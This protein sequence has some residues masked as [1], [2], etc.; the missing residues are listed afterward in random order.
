MRSHSQSKGSGQRHPSHIRAIAGRPGP[1]H[2]HSGQKSLRSQI[3]NFSAGIRA[4]A[5]LL[6]L[7]LIA[8]T[9]ASGLIGLTP[10]G[11]AQAAPGTP[12]T[13]GAPSLIYQEDFQNAPLTGATNIAAYTS[14][15]GATY[16][17]DSVYQ[18]ASRCNG[19]IFGHQATDAA[20]GAAQF[21]AASWWPTAR[22]VPAAIG[23]HAGMADPNTNL[24]VAEQTAGGFND[25]TGVMME[26][27]GINVGGTGRFVTF[28]LDVGNLCNIG[29]QALDR[30]Y[31]ING[32]TPI[33]LNATDYNIC[34]DPNRQTYTVDG[35]V[36]SV[37]TF[38]GNQA[39]LVTNPTVGFRV[40]N[41]QPNGS[42]NDQAFDNFK[43][44]DVT[45]QLDKS[46]S[47]ASVPVGSTSTLTLTVTNTSELGAKNGWSFTDALPT[48]LTV[49][50]PATT[51]C[52][53][54][55]VTAAAGGT[56]VG[57]TGNLSTGL[58]SCTVTVNV[59]SKAA[60]SFTNGPSNVTGTGINPPGTSTVNFVEQPWACDA[61]GYLFQSP[62]GLAD[63]HL[64]QKVD[65]VSGAFS[66]AFTM[67]EA[68]N[69]VGYNVLDNYFYG[70]ASGNGAL[71]RI[72]AN[73]SVAD[74]GVPAG[75][76]GG[77]FVIGDIDNAGRYWVTNGTAYYAIDLVPGSPTF[78]TVLSSGTLPGTNM[79]FD[80][81]FTN[82][83]FYSVGVNGANNVLVSFDPVTGT[84]TV[85]PVLTS[86]AG[87]PVTGLVVG[88]VY[89]DATGYLYASD[90]TTGNISRIDVNTAQMV[91]LSAGPASGGNDGARCASAP[92]PTLTVTK[93]VS[94]R[95][96]PAD[97][98]TVG[99]QA[100]A[101]A[102]LTSA[103]TTGTATTVSTLNQPVS[104]GST[105]TITDAMAAGS[106][107]GINAYNASVACT[108]TATGAT[109]PTAGSGPWTFTVPSAAA[110]TCNVT[111]A[112]VKVSVGLVK[113]ADQAA[114]NS[115]QL[116]QVITYSFEF[117]NTGDVPLT[118]IRINETGFTGTGTAPV[119][120]CPTG[121]V[122]PAAAVTCT[123]TYTVTQADVDAGSISNTATGTGTPPPGITTPPVSPP[124][125]VIVPAPPAPALTV[126]KS[127]SPETITAAG[128]PVTYSFL[129]TNTGN[130]TLKD[131]TVNEGNFT[132]T[133]DLSDVTCDAGA[134]SLAPAATVTCTA[135]YTAT[136]ADVDAGA[137]TNTATATGTPPG[138]T[139][140]PV[141]PPSE[142]TVTIPAAPGITVV[143]SASSETITAAGQ[144]VTYSFLMTNTGNVTLKD[145]TV[146]EGN[147]TGT[148]DLSD[149]TCDAGAASLAPGAT[150]TCTATY[151]VTQADVDAGSISNTATA[152]G[153]PPGTTTPPVSPPS[154]TTVAI[155]AAPGITVVKSAD[156]GALKSLV[157]GQT[158]T[159]SFVVTNTGNVTVTNAAVVEGDFS[160]AGKLSQVTCPDG[161][162]SLAPGAIITC[163]AT[164]TVVQ[165]DLISGTI[166][167][168]AAATGRVPG[169]AALVSAP[170]TAKVA[171]HA[172][173]ITAV[174]ASP[175]NL[176]S[177]GLDPVPL[178]FGGL[179]ILLLGGGTLAASKIRRRQS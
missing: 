139:T 33:A 148:G 57:V 78:N 172:P 168:T 92:I 13:P 170:S 113:T 89:V 129:V 162:A 9:V 134:A 173:V 109:V 43:I 86:P 128:Q 76:P 51:N 135:T 32:T 38:T 165:A 21:C 171:A 112:P 98:F 90:N 158:I 59:T 119:A 11:S 63:P 150:V 15:T 46:F 102:V 110:F 3:Q 154:E 146:N 12:G 133:G 68:V 54:G 155:P 53:A 101:G 115:L 34:A 60:G 20:L 95:A 140:P 50:G 23:Q 166:T 35:N 14:T 124:S 7:A 5:G 24:A 176:A 19:V 121:P 163:S 141:S 160:G 107:S 30:F 18:N 81:G 67:S 103:T 27:S 41:Q 39:A 138:T 10:S 29:V 73:G 72:G 2:R 71:L 58:A 156:A 104:Q 97:Q 161:A 147:F 99:L 45:P 49:A 61:S 69:A 177:T 145:I 157:A 77:A 47:P 137:I 122:A 52:P 79:G 149:V 6:A 26:G 62:A 169:G 116:G 100:P 37:G 8:T 178:V 108:N 132:G 131:I 22:T 106:A 44:L 48:G 87:T 25:Y 94:G 4:L 105:Y 175:A 93:T 64:V 151:T 152:T 84:Q 126:V 136:Q 65:L 88:A 144:S 66:T 96:V 28:S 179:A 40:T 83:A 125:E 127:A 117:T 36:V 91:P 80:W 31:V 74:L 159:Y 143:K 174:P 164:Y 118:D 85:G 42:G 56:S 114:M 142:T 1:S 123:A 75:S 17:M 55:V 16:T 82:G 120:V 167:N 70:I 130:V 111:N 153:T